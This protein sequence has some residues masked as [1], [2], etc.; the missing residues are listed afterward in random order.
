M[1]LDDFERK[2]RGF[3]GLLKRLRVARHISRANCAEINRDRHEEAAY[4]IF[5]IERKF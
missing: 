5:S 2:N 1:I 4:E 3:Y